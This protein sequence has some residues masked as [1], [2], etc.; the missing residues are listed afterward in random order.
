MSWIKMRTSLLTDGRVRKVSA[1]CPQDVHAVVGRLAH[2]WALGDAHAGDDGVLDGWTKQAIDDELRCPGFCDALPSDWLEVTPEGFVKLPNYLEHNGSTGKRRATE[3]KRKKDVRKMSA[4]VSAKCP[5]EMRTREEKRRSTNINN[6]SK[7]AAPTFP[8]ELDTPDCRAAWAEWV[9]YKAGRRQKYSSLDSES[10]ALA[11]VAKHG[12]ARFVKALEK[13]R[14]SNWAGFFP[15]N[16]SDDQPRQ[17]KRD[18]I[19]MFEEARAAK[20]KVKS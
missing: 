1:K 3:Q 4:S 7:S 10:Q 18:V 14:R 20:P 15:E 11:S 5:P 16:E 12:P 6:I 13:A 17:P 9:R 19:A 2:L 8:P